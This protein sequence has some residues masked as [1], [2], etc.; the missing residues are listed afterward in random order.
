MPQIQVFGILYE[1]VNNPGGDCCWLGG[2]S[3]LACSFDG[4]NDQTVVLCFVES[5]ACDERLSL[6][7]FLLPRSSSTTEYQD[8]KEPKMKKWSATWHCSY[9]SYHSSHLPQ[10][11]GR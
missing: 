9:K 7:W 3:K 2:V 5:R 8:L 6:Y 10:A 11:A 1:K 4:K